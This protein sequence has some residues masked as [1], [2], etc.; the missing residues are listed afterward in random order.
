MSELFPG[1]TKPEKAERKGR[2]S[3][4]SAR[5]VDGVMM[6][7]GRRTTNPPPARVAMCDGVPDE[8]RDGIRE[9]VSIESGNP[10]K[11]P[12]HGPAASLCAEADAGGL[13]A[14]AASQY[15]DGDH[16][17]ARAG[18]G[19]LGS[20]NCRAMRAGRCADGEAG[21]DRENALNGRGRFLACSII[22]RCGG[23]NRL[24]C[25]LGGFGHRTHAGSCRGNTTTCRSR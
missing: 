2:A 4:V 13:G 15:A 18:M 10:R 25:G 8:M 14:G 7:P 17:S 24:S 9:I 20:S 11:G 6:E 16:G 22:C 3:A 21:A 1:L 23:P 5:G 12:R 19:D